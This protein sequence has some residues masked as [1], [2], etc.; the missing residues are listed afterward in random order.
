MERL[1]RHLNCA[2]GAHRVGDVV[3]FGVASGYVV[4]GHAAV[5]LYIAVLTLL[6]HGYPVMLQR[7]NRGHV[8]RM[9]RRLDTLGAAWR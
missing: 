7:R 1:L 5:G 6:L 2:E 9:A 3:T 4:A 8:L